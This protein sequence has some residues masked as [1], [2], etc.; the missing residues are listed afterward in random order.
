MGQDHDV[1]RDGSQLTS[2][3]LSIMRTTPRPCRTGQETQIGI[4]K[5]AIDT[6]QD[7]TQTLTGDRD[8]KRCSALSAWL[9]NH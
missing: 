1:G 2:D 9:M 4:G 6:I 7:G 3:N 8:A 5:M